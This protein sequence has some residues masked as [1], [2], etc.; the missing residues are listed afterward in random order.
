LPAIQRYDGVFFRVSRKNLKGV[1]DVDVLVMNDDMILVN[2]KSP[3]QY[4]HP[5]GKKWGS[6]FFSEETY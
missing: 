1:K 5:K 6:Q 2:G 4:F 3:L